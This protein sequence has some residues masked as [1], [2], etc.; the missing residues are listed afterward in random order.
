MSELERIKELI[1][2]HVKILKMTQ[3]TIDEMATKIAERG[4][5]RVDILFELIGNTIAK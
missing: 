4:P 3:S 1:R 5:S 2:P